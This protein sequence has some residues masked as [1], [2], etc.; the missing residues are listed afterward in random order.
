MYIVY[1]NNCTYSVFKLTL[2][3]PTTIPLI[4]SHAW[5][6]GNFLVQLFIST[7]RLTVV[8]I[9]AV[10]LMFM[11]GPLCERKYMYNA[12]MLVYGQLE[13]WII[14]QVKNSRVIENPIGR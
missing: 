7:M 1:T 10:L 2:H 5:F 8:N 12:S 3:A 6:K 14:I 9:F 4:K 11:Y 13:P